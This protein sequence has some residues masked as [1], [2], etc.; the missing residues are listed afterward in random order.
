MSINASTAFSVAIDSVKLRTDLTEKQKNEI[1]SLLHNA[2]QRDWFVHWDKEKIIQA[3]MDYKD[4]T[5][6]APTVT[7]LCETGMP[8]SVT[9]QTHCGM[10]ASLFLKQLFPENRPTKQAV[11]LRYNPYGFETMDD[12]LECFTIQFTKHIDGMCAKKYNIV[13]DE[14]TPTWETIARHCQC[15][16]WKELMEKAGVE[17]SKNKVQNVTQLYV[18]DAGSPLITKFEKLNEERRQLNQELFEIFGKAK[19]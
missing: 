4:R 18:A 7:N 12:W 16:N 10:K 6:R 9:I 8:K 5:G 15:A 13:R 14:G 3:L 11:A 17:Y 1:V 19:K 2:A